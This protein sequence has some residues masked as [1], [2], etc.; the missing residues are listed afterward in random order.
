MLTNIFVEQ[1]RRLFVFERLVR[2]DM[3]PMAGGIADRQQ[4][5]F[6]G[7]AGEFKRL[8]AP[9]VPVDRIIGMLQEVGAGFLGEAIRHGLL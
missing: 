5:G 3:A 4:Y 7:L 9:R 8:L 1:S 2:H 6:A